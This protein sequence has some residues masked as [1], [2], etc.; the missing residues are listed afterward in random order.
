[1][2][3]PRTHRP[4]S[5]SPDA[6]RPPWAAAGLHQLESG[7][8][9]TKRMYAAPEARGTGAG[10]AILRTWEEA[11]QRWGIRRIILETGSLNHAA[12]ALSKTFGGR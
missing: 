1:M 11:A 4:F 9:E 2:L 8:A 3:L 12:R 7:T 10:Q 6:D 5:S